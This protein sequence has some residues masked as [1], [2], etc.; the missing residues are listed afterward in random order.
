MA[1]KKF[2]FR[3][4]LRFGSLSTSM[5]MFNRRDFNMP[6]DCLSPL[7]PLALVDRQ[8]LAVITD[9]NKASAVYALHGQLYW[10]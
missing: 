9:G 10:L 7:A 5:P 1:L 4:H 8:S 3:F 2:T 6:M